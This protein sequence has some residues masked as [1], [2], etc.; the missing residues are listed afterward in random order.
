VDDIEHALID[1]LRGTK[2]CKPVQVGRAWF[3]HFWRHK[4]ARGVVN[5]PWVKDLRCKQFAMM[6]YES[7]YLEQARR[8]LNQDRVSFYQAH[9]F[10]AP[11]PSFAEEVMRWYGAERPWVQ[12]AN[13]PSRVR[14]PDGERRREVAYLD[15]SSTVFQE[16]L[17]RRI[18]AFYDELHAL[19]GVAGIIVAGV[20]LN[21]IRALPH[22][23]H[24]KVL[25][26]SGE[27]DC[28]SQFGLLCNLTNFQQAAECL[29][30]K[31][32][33]YLHCGMTPLIHG[34]FAESIDYCDRWGVQPAVYYS[35]EQAADL[36]E[37]QGWQ[38][39]GD[40]NRFCIQER[41]GDLVAEL[42]KIGGS[43]A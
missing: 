34:T 39:G 20:F 43:V 17:Y 23:D 37:F 35:A 41:I 27:Y 25:S 8:Y 26:M 42:Q 6:G 36:T 21:D 9:A 2:R 11:T 16:D 5:V 18:I 15:Y 19:A 31:L 38:A 7:D 28:R 33:F 10:V 14:V 32:L 3:Y 22:R 4:P 13:Y 29:P 30:R 24:V 12:F 40:R 1:V